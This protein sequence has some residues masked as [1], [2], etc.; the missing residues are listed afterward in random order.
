MRAAHAQTIRDSRNP[1]S[2][3]AASIR[4]YEKQ[5]LFQREPNKETVVVND[6]IESYGNFIRALARTLTASTE[7]AEAAMQE[8]YIDI[9][10]YAGQADA[11]KDK[12]EAQIVSLIA[13]RRLLKYLI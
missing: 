5:G 13:C 8:I 7:E 2:P 12:A 10:R 4:Q 11:P 6:V 1:S 9:R 3:M